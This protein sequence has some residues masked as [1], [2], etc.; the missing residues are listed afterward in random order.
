MTPVP[1]GTVFVRQGVHVE[2]ETDVNEHGQQDYRWRRHPK[3]L[4][5]YAMTLR[6]VD[7]S[8]WYAERSVP[9]LPNTG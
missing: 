6:A 5:L 7:M 9:E 8:R 1:A 3:H 2:V 4:W